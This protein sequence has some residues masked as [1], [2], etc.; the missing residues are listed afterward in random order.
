MF[1]HFEF[2]EVLTGEFHLGRIDP[3]YGDSETFVVTNLYPTMV[4]HVG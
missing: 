4:I 1:Y 3:L 2:D